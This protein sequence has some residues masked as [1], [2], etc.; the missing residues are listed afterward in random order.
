MGRRGVRS[1]QSMPHT[2]VEI[3]S[4]TFPVASCFLLVRVCDERMKCR[5]VMHF[6]KKTEN[7]WGLSDEQQ[8]HCWSSFKCCTGF[9]RARKVGD[10]AHPPKCLTPVL[11][12][13]ILPVDND[14]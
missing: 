7:W 1:V 5:D 13:T 4:S 3:T 2:S 10:A 9:F 12:V 14:T 6:S 11:A 8:T